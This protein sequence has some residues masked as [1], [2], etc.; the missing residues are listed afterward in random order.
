[1]EPLLVYPDPPPE[2][3]SRALERAGYPW[4]G[5]SDPAVAERDEPEDGFAGAVISALDDPATAFAACRTLRK[6][7]GALRPLSSWCLRTAWR[8]WSYVRTCSTTSSCPAATVEELE[9]RLTHLF[10]RTGRGKSTDIIVYGPLALKP[11]RR[12]RRRFRDGPSTSRTWSTSCSGS[13]PHTG[14]GVQSGDPL[15][16]RVWGYEYF[17]GARTVDVHV[18]GASGPRWAEEH[19]HLI[20]HGPQRRLPIRQR[21]AGCR[22]TTDLGADG[23]SRPG[24]AVP[25]SRSTTP[26]A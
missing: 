9:A 19:A 1:M 23:P 6:G 18:Q 17:G 12:T 25:H 16:A 26:L 8:S 15:V 22:P 21:S 14:A 3:V 5:V 13:S 11:S 4:R 7:D 20:G 2:W 24:V 10:W